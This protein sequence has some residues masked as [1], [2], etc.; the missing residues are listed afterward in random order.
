[1]PNI[2]K[3]T[4]AVGGTAT[5]LTAAARREM[6]RY[7]RLMLA[8]KVEINT[9]SLASD[10]EMNEHCKV[11]KKG[12]LVRWDMRDNKTRVPQHAEE[13]FSSCL[14]NRAYEEEE[15]TRS[16]EVHIIAMRD[17]CLKRLDAVYPHL[18]PF[19]L[20][21]PNIRA[22][23][24]TPEE[25]VSTSLDTSRISQLYVPGLDVAAFF[26]PSAPTSLSLASV[27]VSHVAALATTIKHYGSC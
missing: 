1:M 18:A 25:A 5:R 19:S 13:L 11:L 6:A 14:V 12:V 24:V 23:Y 8:E 3:A 26:G 9:T 22:A 17:L 4:V 2:L 27:P 21:A 15:E 20:S 10:V 7:E 16:T